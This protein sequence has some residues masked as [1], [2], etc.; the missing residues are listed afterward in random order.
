[1]VD[2]RVRRKGQNQETIIRCTAR[3]LPPAAGSAVSVRKQEA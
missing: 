2:R 3:H 1:L